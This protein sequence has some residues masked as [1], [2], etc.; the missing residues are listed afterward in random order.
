M[1]IIEKYHS[2]DWDKGNKNK[3]WEGH[4]VTDNECEEIFFNL[5]LIKGTDIKHSII[6]ERFYVLGKTDRGRLLFIIFT[7]RNNKIR[8]ISARDMT[9]K[10]REVYYEHKEK[11]IKV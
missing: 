7:V 5:P 2:F 3:N 10:E 9:R 6:E 8:I 11:D 4:K 1:E